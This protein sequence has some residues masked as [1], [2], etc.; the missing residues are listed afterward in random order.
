M[1]KV[2]EQMGILAELDMAAFA[3]CCQACARW[4]E[5]EKFI[6]HHGSMIR[7]PN[8]YLQ[9]A[10]QVSIARTNMKIMLP[11]SHCDK[12]KADRAV[13]FIQNLCRTKGWWAGTPFT[14]FPWQ[15]QI[16]RDI[17]GIVKENGSFSRP[18]WRYSRN[19]ANR[20]WPLR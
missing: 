13:T 16:V 17:F 7:T 2:L 20:S 11:I 14:L 3:G 4:K 5:A 18:M 6:T 9:Q 12:D 1:G 15:E 19:R 10:P 8:G